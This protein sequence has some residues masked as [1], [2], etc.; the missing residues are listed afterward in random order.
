MPRWSVWMQRSAMA[1]LVLGAALG[2]LLLAGTPSAVPVLVRAH[3]EM[4]LIGWVT[5][6]TMGT[7]HWMLPKHAAGP[8]RGPEW[9]VAVAWLLLNGGVIACGFGRGPSW[10]LAG[11]VAQVLAIFAFGAV[12]LPRIKPFGAGR[13]APTSPSGRSAAGPA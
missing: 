6:F 13:L 9:L 10:V 5:Q 12:A 4:M 2:A 1:W 7:A 8:A 3:L 11:R